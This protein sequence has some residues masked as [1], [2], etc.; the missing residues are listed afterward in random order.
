MGKI[1]VISTLVLVLS[2]SL[3]AQDRERSEHW[4]QRNSQFNT[5][6]S[7]VPLNAVVFLGNSI[8]EGFDLPTAFPGQN[9]INRGIIGDHLDGVIERLDNSALALKPKKIF[10][11]MGINDIG[12][13]RDDDYIMKMYSLLLDTLQSQLP[14]TEI[15]V[16]SILP[17]SPRWKNCPP[18]QIKRINA[19][20]ALE[21]LKRELVYVNLYPYFLRGMNYINMDLSRDGLH[22]NQAGYELWREKVLPYLK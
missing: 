22:P 18:D 10:L 16:H 19:C 14:D 4:Q 1:S 15:Y 5:E 6:L 21:A 11:L 13:R 9:V 17:T 3:P 7:S 2:I 8:T 20:L 12:D